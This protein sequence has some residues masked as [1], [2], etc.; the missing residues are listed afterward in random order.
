MTADINTAFFKQPF[1]S[2]QSEARLVEYTVLDVEPTSPRGAAGKGQQQQEQQ[3]GQ[4]A[5]GKRVTNAMIEVALST[6]FGVNDNTHIALSHLVR[7]ARQAR[8]LLC[9]RRRRR[10]C[11]CCRIGLGCCCHFGWGCCCRG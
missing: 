11:C 7:Y 2:M 9:C 8:L 3:G 10:R 1:K 5:G 6:D 4:A